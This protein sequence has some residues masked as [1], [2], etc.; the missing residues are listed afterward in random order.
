MRTRAVPVFIVFLLNGIIAGSWAPRMPSL[1]EQIGAGPG[2]LGLVLLG[3]SVG[4]AAAASVAGRLC[5]RFGARVMIL[6]SAVAAAGLLPVLA[7][8]SSPVQLGL[9]LVLLGASFGVFDVSMN[10]AA[11][12]V[13][14]RVERPLM[15]V[16]HA[17][18]SF[19]ALGG[20]LAAAI[21]AGHRVDLL[22]YFAVVA[23]VSCAI[24]A[25]V[26]RFVPTEKPTTGNPLER[27]G[28]DRS[29]LRRPVLWLL[30]GVAFLSAV[31]EG[32]N[33]DW[34]ALFAVRE[35]GMSEAAGALMYSVFCLA[36]GMMRLFGERIQRRFGAIRILVAGSV[37][38]GVGLL[39]AAIV[40]V[41]WLTYAG[42][43]LAGGG[44]AFAFP[45]VIDLAGAVGRRSDGT[46]GEREIGFVTAIAYSGFL[47]GPPMIGGVAEL[48][49]LSV[50]VGFIGVVAM[51]MAP[52]ALAAAA[53]RRRE[54]RGRRTQTEPPRDYAHTER[55][56]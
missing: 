38:A 18:F 52:V 32:S 12:T 23:L 45:V 22:T 16:F 25:A 31:V 14:R 26:I 30:G 35:R 44:V 47:I 9:V 24:T 21:A 37:L 36:M 39:T 48:T 33:A 51:L 19:G 41:A 46:G 17:A 6:V 27:G 4:L 42:Y 2:V 55:R 40:P 3:A 50:A 11:V 49:N 43:A 7:L 54:D 10:V 53:A 28:L 5:A 29:M 8:V 56:G 34:S 13:I 1:A 15:A 20:S